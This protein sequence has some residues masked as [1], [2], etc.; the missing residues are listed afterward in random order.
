[1]AKV[2]LGSMND[3]T[4]NIYECLYLKGRMSTFIG[5]YWQK[6]ENKKVHKVVFLFTDNEHLQ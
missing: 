4:D 3:F 6:I 1:M 2:S 5:I